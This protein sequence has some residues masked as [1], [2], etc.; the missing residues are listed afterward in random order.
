MRIKRNDLVIILTGKERGQ[1]GR[2]LRVE[3]RRN[4]VVVEGRA[5]VQRHRKARGQGQESAIVPQEAAIDASNVALYSEK[6]KRGVRVCSRY[7][8]ANGALFATLHEARKSMGDAA[9]KVRKVRYA[10]KTGELFE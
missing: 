6:L 2:V 8:G 9:E 7:V 1:T 5:V 4:R 3:P 10:P